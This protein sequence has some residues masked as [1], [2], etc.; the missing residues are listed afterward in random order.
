MNVTPNEHCMHR[1][2]LLKESQSCKLVKQKLMDV[3]EKSVRD[4]NFTCVQELWYPD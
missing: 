3:K 1:K 2:N 4:T